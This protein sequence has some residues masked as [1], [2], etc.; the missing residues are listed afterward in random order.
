MFFRKDAYQPF[1]AAAA[2]PG[3]KV[4]SLVLSKRK[5]YHVCVKDS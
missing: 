3:Q 2:T 1:N 5:K 4:Q